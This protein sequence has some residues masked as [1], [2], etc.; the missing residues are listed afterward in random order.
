MKSE[1]E[2]TTK[3]NYGS[4]DRWWYPRFWNGMDMASWLRLLARNRF[5]VGPR[6]LAMAAIHS[7]ITPLNTALRGW[8]SL[9][10]GRRIERTE[11]IDDPIFVIGH[12]RSGTTLLHEL[13]VLDPRFTYADT[14][15]CYAPNHFLT[16]GWL[17]RP[18]VG[19][20]L[21]KRRP[22]DNMAAGWDKPQ[23][24][25]FALCNMGVR[26]PY[27]TIAFPNRPQD[28]EYFEL[29]DVPPEEL[30]RW[31]ES[32][33]W[34][35][36]CITVQDAKR[37]VL[38]SP[39]HTFRIKVLTEMFPRAKFI[40]IVRDPFVLFPSTVNLWRRLYRDQGFQT[41]RFED[42]EE[43]IFRV[44]TEMYEVFERDRRLLAPGQICDVRYE[45]LV[46]Q[47]IEQMQQ[48][49]EKLELGDVD[50]VLPAWRRYFADKADYKTNRYEVSPQLR[51]VIA[52]RWRDY[53][54]R[55]GYAT[56]PVEA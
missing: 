19:L 25:E 31:K 4:K 6:C 56:E 55:Y 41:P 33:L 30:R 51:E 48:V 37:I 11:L 24:D 40:H 14:Y 38:K 26:S 2:K 17:I 27:Y 50:E 9:R 34:F 23:E 36:K 21:P 49:Y 5:Q 20:L 54:E 12:W 46:Q 13:M 32:L 8:Q 22:M 42:M 53:F 39:P 43:Q 15:E 16:S 18:T 47:P 52:R 44:L 28:E 1:S 7:S 10:Y 35:L 3:R 45:D 29:A